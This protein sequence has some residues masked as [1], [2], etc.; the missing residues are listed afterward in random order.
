MVADSQR[1]RIIN[2]DDVNPLWLIQAKYAARG[3]GQDEIIRP[4]PTRLD[5]LNESITRSVQS[6]IGSRFDQYRDYIGSLVDKYPNS[7]IAEDAKK[8]V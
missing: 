7:K 8:G 5:F 1:D 4:N 3:T 6:K 2:K